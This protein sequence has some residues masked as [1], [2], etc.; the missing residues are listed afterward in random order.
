MVKDSINL[1]GTKCTVTDGQKL[2]DRQ[3]TF[4]IYFVSRQIGKTLNT[5]EVEAKISALWLKPEGW[6]RDQNFGLEISIEAKVK[7]VVLRTKPRPNA[8]DWDGNFGL[9]TILVSRRP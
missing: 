8:L 6:D 2:T 4:S 3:L 1:I 9:K 5:I 7:I